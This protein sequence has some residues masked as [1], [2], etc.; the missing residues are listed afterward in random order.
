MLRGCYVAS[1]Y[2]AGYEASGYVASYTAS[3]YVDGYVANGYD[4]NIKWNISIF[5]KTFI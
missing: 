3:S 2:M 4:R 5:M 1:G